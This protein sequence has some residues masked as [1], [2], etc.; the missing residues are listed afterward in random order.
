MPGSGIGKAR[1]LWF[2]P[3]GRDPAFMRHMRCY[4]AC[5][6]REEDTPGLLKRP[7][8][9]AA[10]TDDHMLWPVQRS[11]ISCM[12]QQRA[13]CPVERDW[14]GGPQIVRS[15]AAVLQ[16]HCS[17]AVDKSAGHTVLV[18]DKHASLVHVMNRTNSS[19]RKMAAMHEMTATCG[20]TSERSVCYERLVTSGR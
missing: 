19:N 20:E 8:D 10:R 2:S 3:E 11:W 5:Q 17:V 6:H 4:G 14:H 18:R 12:R 9:T 1:D 16:C 15:A 13:W 7:P